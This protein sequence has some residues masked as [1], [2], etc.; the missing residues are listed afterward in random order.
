MD[1]CSLGY[2]GFDTVDTKAWA[3]Y[4]P[5]VLGFGL[6]PA[7]DAETV[8]LRMDDRRYRIALHA[9]E[10][11][12]IAYMGWELQNRPAFEAAVDELERGGV[13]VDAGDDDLAERRGVHA[14][15]TFR[16]PVGYRHEIF[17]GQESLPHSFVPGRAFGGFVA[18]NLGLGHVV[19]AVPEVTDELKRFATDVMGLVWTGQGSRKSSAFYRPSGNLR[20]HA[21]AYANIPGHFGIHHMGISVQELDDVGIAYDLAEERGLQIQTTIGRHTQDAV[22][23]FYHYSPSGLM[24]EYITGDEYVTATTPESKPERLSLWGHKVLVEGLPSTVRPID[25]APRG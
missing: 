7:S 20:S 14:L 18:G 21:I 6:A 1:I 15:A 25:A 4:A 16:D 9:G 12:R 8:Y 10:R 19:L 11:D 13:A 2:L 3:D 22:I 17:Y 5:A 23:S 24:L